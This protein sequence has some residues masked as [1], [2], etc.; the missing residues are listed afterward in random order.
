MNAT[1]F[2]FSLAAAGILSVT[3][4]GIGAT[5]DMPAT[6]MSRD[7]FH[8]AERELEARGRAALGL[9]RGQPGPER[10]LCRAEARAESRVRHAE[11]QARYHGTIAAAEEARLARVR[12]EYDIAKVR[13]RIDAHGDRAGCLRSARENRARAVAAL[14]RAAAT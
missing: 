7:D 12:A 11:L 9:C 5:V 10:E 6:L 1:T 14:R 2:C 3:A 8:A 4:L 13:C